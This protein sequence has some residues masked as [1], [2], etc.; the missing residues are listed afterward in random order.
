[1]LGRKEKIELF[2]ECE[3]C[4]EIVPCGNYCSSCGKKQFNKIEFRKISF[5]QQVRCENC[6]ERVYN[7]NN[8]SN[9]GFWFRKAV[10]YGNNA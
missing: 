6:G 8:C 4:K 10:Q 3:I 9:C 1:M 5:Q 7:D 2:L